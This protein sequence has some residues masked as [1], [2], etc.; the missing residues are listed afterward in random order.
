MEY[1]SIALL[2]ALVLMTAGIIYLY[3]PRAEIGWI[4]LMTVCTLMIAVLIF[5]IHSN[6]PSQPAPSYSQR[7]AFLFTVQKL[8]IYCKLYS[9]KQYS[10]LSSSS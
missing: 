10:S 2:I 1:S 5:M 6:S 7:A 3:F 8:N 9:C 4:L